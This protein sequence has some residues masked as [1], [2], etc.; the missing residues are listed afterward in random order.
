MQLQD[1]HDV[2]ARSVEVVAE[3]GE[4]LRAELQSGV[5]RVLI[6]G[7][8]GVMILTHPAL[9][10]LRKCS[11]VPVAYAHGAELLAQWDDRIDGGTLA[12]IPTV[13]G[14]TAETV[15]LADKLRQSGAR[16]LALTG[17]PDSPVADLATVSL[18]T[19]MTDATSSEV[20]YMQ[21][22]GAALHLM[23]QVDGA[24]TGAL[25]EDLTAL[26]DALIEAK[27]EYT[28]SA[29]RDAE[30]IA[31]SDYHI[32]ASAGNTW[33]EA[34]YYGMCILE[35]MQWIRTRPVH[36][37]DFFHGTLE[38]V[39]PGVSVL[40]MM[41]EGPMRTLS[42]RVSAFAPRFT[43]RSHV[44]DTSVLTLTGLREAA[45]ILYSPIALAT[46]LDSVSR[47][48]EQIR[49]HPLTTRRYYKKLEY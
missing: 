22:L 46:I 48:L 35:E 5:R 30:F 32:I 34:H 8:G 17:K 31:A 25:L 4:L 26:P 27:R 6:T 16:V 15:E 42:E 24:D 45:R 36:A 29:R 49:N 12:I 40:T 44:I 11:T 41:G 10:L 2:F 7:A 21:T 20:V 47:E 37:S 38:L 39:E 28:D 13:S 18:S 9:E 33:P 14:S 23:H 43:D 19:P 1:Y 3:I